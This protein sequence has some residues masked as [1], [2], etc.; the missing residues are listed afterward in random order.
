M[1]L[2]GFWFQGILIIVI[3][4]VVIFLVGLAFKKKGGY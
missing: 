4:V 2:G 3:C 1:L